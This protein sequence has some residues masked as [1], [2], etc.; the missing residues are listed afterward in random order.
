MGRSKGGK[1]GPVAKYPVETLPHPA[2]FYWGPIID[3]HTARSLGLKRFFTGEP[4]IHNHIC[5]RWSASRSCVECAKERHRTAEYRERFNP[6]EKESWLRGKDDYN[7]Q[8]R[9]VIASKP[10]KSEARREGN[11]R[12]WIARRAD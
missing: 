12:A 7:A 3:V 11:R 2:E 4:C 9:S 1:K 5:E 8:R 6:Q 10:V